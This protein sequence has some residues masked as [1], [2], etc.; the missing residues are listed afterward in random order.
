MLLSCEEI[1]D[2]TNQALINV[3]SFMGASIDSNLIEQAVKKCSPWVDL[4]A[5]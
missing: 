2:N 3:L 4:G 1:H 5:P